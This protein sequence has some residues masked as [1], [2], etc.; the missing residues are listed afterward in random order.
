RLQLGGYAL[1]IDGDQTSS[2][3]TASSSNIKIDQPFG[4]FAQ[5]DFRVD[6]TGRISLRLEAGARQAASLTFA[7]HF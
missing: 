6:W 3:P 1:Y 4:G 5:A 2:G 7:R